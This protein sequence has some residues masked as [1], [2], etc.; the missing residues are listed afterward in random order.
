MTLDQ[1][2]RALRGT[3]REARMLVATTDGLRPIV[4]VRSGWVRGDGTMGPDGGEAVY[5]IVLELAEPIRQQQQE[6]PDPE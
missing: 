3:P 6:E 5:S 2:A 4:L 1:L